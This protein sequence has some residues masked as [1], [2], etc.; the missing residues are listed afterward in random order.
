MNAVVVC[1]YDDDEIVDVLIVEHEH[2]AD[3][4][5]AWEKAL[6]QV[7]KESPEEWQVSDV[8]SILETEGWQILRPDHVKVTY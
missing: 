5:I 1:P 4:G 8:H 3:F 6:E 2:D 7:K